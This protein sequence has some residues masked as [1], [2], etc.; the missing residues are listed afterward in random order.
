MLLL[1]MTIQF[2]D[3]MGELSYAPVIRKLVLFVASE[4]EYMA[5]FIGAAGK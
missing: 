4:V 3:E 1:L 2:R 5:I